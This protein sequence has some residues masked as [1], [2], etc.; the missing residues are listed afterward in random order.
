MAIHHVQFHGYKVYQKY[1]KINQPGGGAVGYK[2]EI[3]FHCMKRKWTRKEQM[4]V[5][6]SRTN[7]HILVLSSSCLKGTWSPAPPQAQF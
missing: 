4:A 5:S 2:N 7:K 1:W 3:N 6:I